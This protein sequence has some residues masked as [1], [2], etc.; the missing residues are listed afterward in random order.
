[1]AKKA[2]EYIKT[3]DH[4]IIDEWV[5]NV[6]PDSA[7]KVIK[8]YIP[9]YRKT[10]KFRTSMGAATI[11]RP[12]AGDFQIVINYNSAKKCFVVWNAAIQN[13]IHRGQ[14]M[15][16]T[17]GSNGED[18]LRKTINPDSIT[19][20]FRKISKGGR[21]TK[22]VEQLLLIGENALADFC[23]NYKE[24]ILPDKKEIPEGK[25]CLYAVAGGEIEYIQRDEFH[26]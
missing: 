14:K 4:S 25:I 24:K 3:G 15:R 13:K 22:Y 7:K 1:M 23:K 16:L 2:K 21:D 18:L 17:I 12:I 19:V 9:N 8:D 6:W 20:F 10:V 5:N 11:S 26:M